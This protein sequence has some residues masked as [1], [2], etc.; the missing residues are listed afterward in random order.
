MSKMLKCFFLSTGTILWISSQSQIHSPSNTSNTDLIW[1]YPSNL[2]Q[3]SL[4]NLTFWTLMMSWT[5]P[6]P[7]K[8]PTT[9]P[10]LLWNKWPIWF[11]T[12]TPPFVYFLSNASAEWSTTT[13][14]MRIIS[15][16]T[17]STCFF[18]GGK[19]VLKRLVRSQF[20]RYPFS[21]EVT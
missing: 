9:T 21:S 17:F 1:W 5:I 8:R 2:W 4:L 13:E 15:A 19:P 16:P 14:W 6:A 20:I 11:Y 10:T 18:C 7:I 12:R 3:T